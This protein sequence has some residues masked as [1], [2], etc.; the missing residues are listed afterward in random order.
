MITSG[1][2]SSMTDEWATPTELFKQLDDEFHF[3]LDPCASDENHKCEKYFTIADDGLRKP[4]GGSQSFLQ[5]T[6]RE[7]Y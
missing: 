3:E 5:S 1:W 4:W 6:L 7:I 2:F